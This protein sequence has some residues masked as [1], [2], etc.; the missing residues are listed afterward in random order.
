MTPGQAADV[1]QAEGLLGD[2]RPG[3]VVADKAYDSDELVASIEACGAAAVIP[4]KSNRK[5]QR[6]YDRHVYKQ[7]SA[8]EQFIGRI[9]EFRRVATRYDKTARNYLGFVYL[10]CIID[11][12]R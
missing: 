4:P 9:K 6:E 12:L 3:A 7:R 8:V 10:A 5:V 1:T 11:L 2:L